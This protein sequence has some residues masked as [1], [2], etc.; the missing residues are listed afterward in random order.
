MS[1]A[2]T[3]T[4]D[5]RLLA[6]VSRWRKDNGWTDSSRGWINEADVADASV[7]VKPDPDVPNAFTVTWRKGNGGW[8]Q[9][10][11]YL[12]VDVQQALDFLV[13]LKVLPA[14]FSSAYQ[15]A[16]G[17]Y[18]ELLAAVEQVI[19]KGR[20]DFEHPADGDLIAAYQAVTR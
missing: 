8:H 19:A 10:D 20:L 11:D 1:A 12:A 3:P 9:P 14:Q 15:V 5:R 17:S 7:A 16:D 2:S 13:A 4:E 18:A 6:E